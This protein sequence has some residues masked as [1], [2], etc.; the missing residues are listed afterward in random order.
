MSLPYPAGCYA[1]VVGESL[2]YRV[3]CRR[4]V[5]PYSGEIRLKRVGQDG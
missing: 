2:N 1:G 4:A 3:L 5:Y